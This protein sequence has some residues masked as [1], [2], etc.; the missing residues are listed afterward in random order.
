M[1]LKVLTVYTTCLAPLAAGEVDLMAAETMFNYT[2]QHFLGG[3]RFWNH[4][5]ETWESDGCMVRGTI[6][7]HTCARDK[8]LYS[9]IR[10]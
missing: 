7:H 5:N 1:E 10:L 2:Y 8:Y 6:T 9:K 3:C 4:E